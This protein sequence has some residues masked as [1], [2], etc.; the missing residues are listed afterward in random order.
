MG[1]LWYGGTFYSMEKEGDKMDAVFTSNGVIQAVGTERSLRETYKNQITEEHNIKGATAYPGFVDSHLHII[2]HGEK[3]THLDLSPMKS[4]EEVLAALED[5]VQT[6]QKGEWLVGE[7]WNE[8]QWEHP[9]I[10]SKIELDEVA[11]DQP[12]ILTRVCRHAILANSK[13]IQLAGIHKDTPDP[14]G[15]LIERNDNGEETGFFLDTAQDII[16]KVVPEVSEEYLKNL[17]EKSVDDLTRLGLVGGHTEDLNYYGGYKKTYQAFKRGINGK[18]RKF[19]A[20]LLIHHGVFDEVMEDGLDYGDGTGFIELGAMKIFSD[21]ALGGRT[22]WLSEPYV[23]EPGNYG[24]P[25]HS[26][27]ELE[28]LVKKA[29]EKDMP[30][31]VHAI[32]DKAAITIARLIEKYPLHKNRRD[33]IIHA[34]IVNSEL[35]DILKRVPVVLDIQPTF[36]ASDFPWVIE[37]VGLERAKQSYPWKTFL[38]FGIPCAGGSDAPIESVN[39]LLGIQAAVLRQSSMDGKTYNEDQCLTLYEAISLYTKGSAFAIS[40]ENQMGKIAPG[41][42]ADFTILEEDLSQVEPSAISQVKVMKT[43]IDEDVVYQT[44]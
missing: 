14:Q 37:R 27:E 13:A 10:L 38:E 2:G 28:V 18:Q 44:K 25:I 43:V 22:A 34:Q 15:G 20:H 40:K 35:L 11:P 24:I 5:R 41:Y 29:R 1:V 7:G 31:A 3:L 30:V 39:P 17:V 26:D 36:V 6:M 32:G 16:K 12:M 19:R 23:D 8:N 21:G 9:R 33:R 42:V 4:A